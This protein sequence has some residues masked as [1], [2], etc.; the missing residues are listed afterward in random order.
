MKTFT[1]DSSELTPQRLDA[2]YYLGQLLKNA[3]AGARRALSQARTARV[4]ITTQHLGTLLE[5]LEDIE[6]ENKKLRS[7]LARVQAVLKA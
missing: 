2:S 6:A 7:K 5:A 1:V 4:I 3:K